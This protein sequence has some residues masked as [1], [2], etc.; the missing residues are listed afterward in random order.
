MK[1]YFYF[2]LIIL[3]IPGKELMAGGVEY[4]LD[5]AFKNSPML[6]SQAHKTKA[7]EESYYKESIFKKNPV[8]MFGY[9][10]MPVS[11]PSMGNHAMSNITFGVSQFIAIPWESSNRKKTFYH[12]HLSEKEA[13]NESRNM[14]AFQVQRLYHSLMFLYKKKEIILKNKTVLINISKT[15]ESLVSVNK[16]NSSHLLKL[17]ADISIINNKIT[18]V[19]GEILALQAKMESLCGSKLVWNISAVDSKNWINA[20]SAMVSPSGFLAKEHPLYKK[21]LE[22]YNAGKAAHELEK[23]KLFPGVNLGFNYS[24]RQEISGKDSGEDF[25]SFKVST[26]LPL[27]YPLKENHSISAAEEK[28]KSLQEMLR[29]I[30]ISLSGEW[31]GSGN[32]LKKQQESFAAFN[33]EILPGYMAAYQ[34]Q[35]SSLAAGSVSLLDVL[36]TYRLFLKASLNEAILYK[37]LMITRLKLQYLLYSYPGKAGGNK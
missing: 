25:L 18:E 8:F 1:I 9:M 12:K 26:P 36:D 10:N 13:L 17:K 37:K 19:D 3:L 7:S 27:F 35:L 22:L 14:L 21:M 30:N 31:E 5:E 24:V 34:A 15:A 23:A 29:N 20:G 4:F 6:K 32:M 11:S 33:K 28:K 2:L 16:M